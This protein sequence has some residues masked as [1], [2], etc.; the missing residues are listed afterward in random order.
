MNA[1][2]RLFAI[3]L[4]VCLL[5]ACNR[6]GPELPAAVDDDNNG[7]NRAAQDPYVVTADAAKTGAAVD[8]QGAIAEAKSVFAPNETVFLSMESKGRRLGA[9][10]TV[11]WFYADGTSR[12]E[13]TKQLS[14]PYVYFEYQ[15]TETGQFRAEVDVNDRPIGLIDFEVK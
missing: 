10:V 2:L 4:L 8:E 14:G 1:S 13:E 15:P 3:G 7:A 9:R 5:A 6:Q 11:Y 12:K